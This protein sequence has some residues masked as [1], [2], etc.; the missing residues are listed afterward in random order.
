MTLALSYERC[1]RTRS[2]A[3]SCRACVEACPTGAI[4]Y[5]DADWTGLM[6]MRQWA[7]KLDVQPQA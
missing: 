2:V 7:G 3:S 1:V 4:T 5:V 6:R